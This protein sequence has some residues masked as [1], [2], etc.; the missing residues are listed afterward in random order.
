MNKAFLR[1]VIAILDEDT[2]FDSKQIEK[3]IEIEKEH[4]DTI[5]RIIED[6]QKEQIKPLSEY[7]KGITFDHLNEAP[8]YYIAPDG[9]DRLDELEEKAN[10]E[11]KAKR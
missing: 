1:K 7:Y 3:G 9:T 8:L 6:T 5:E 4:K 11:L 2:K 10:E